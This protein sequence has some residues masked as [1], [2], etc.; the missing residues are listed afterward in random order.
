MQE[1]GDIRQIAFLTDDI[2]SA[3]QSWMEKSG[4]GPFTCY[5]NLSLPTQYEGELRNIVMDVGIA[6]RGDMQIELIQQ[7]NDVLSPYSAQIEKQ[8]MG[9][10]HF[11]YF[12]QDMDASL[13]EIKA[14]GMK[15]I[16]SSNAATGRF[17]YFQDPLMPENMFEFMEVSDT[18][19]NYW[20][21][22]I[23]AAKNWDGKPLIHEFDMSNV[24]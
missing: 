13:D 21:D 16:S 15:V 17:A 10:H 20:Q 24:V 14:K 1:L 7:K 22:S 11:A 8:Q 9:F 18:L 6:F 4:L 3:M 12:T 2:D 5:R 19:T 23:A